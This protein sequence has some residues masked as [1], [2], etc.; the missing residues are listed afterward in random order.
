MKSIRRKSKLNAIH[1]I[2]CVFGKAGVS[3]RVIVLLTCA[4]SAYTAFAQNITGKVVDENNKP[5][6]FV[7]VVIKANITKT[8]GQDIILATLKKLMDC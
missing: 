5:M 7:N 1:I 2:N 6:E 4:F 3:Q 8:K